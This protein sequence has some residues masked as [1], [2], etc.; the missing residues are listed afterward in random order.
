MTD[1]PHFSLPFRFASPQARRERAE[2]VPGGYRLKPEA[3]KQKKRKG[4]MPSG[5][6]V[7]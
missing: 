5:R 4:V 2:L 1:V 7:D 3:Y 6:L